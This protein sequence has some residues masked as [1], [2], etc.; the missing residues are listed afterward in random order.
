MDKLIIEGGRPLAGLVRVSGA[1]NSVFPILAATILAEGPV[2]LHNVPELRDVSTMAK[3]LEEM[4]AVTSSAE[5]YKVDA[6][7]LSSFRAPYELVKTMRASFLVLG[8][9]LAKYGKAEVSLPG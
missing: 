3:L 8:P 7:S 9:L 4:G 2:Q 5:K 6:S 1:K